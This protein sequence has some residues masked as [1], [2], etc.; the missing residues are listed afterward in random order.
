MAFTN[1]RAQKQAV[2]LILFLPPSQP[3]AAVEAAL[4][5]V[6]HQQRADRAVADQAMEPPHQ[7][8]LAHLGRDTRAATAQP[9]LELAAVVALAR[10]AATTPLAARLEAAAMVFR[11]QSPA[12]PPITAAAVA[13]V[14]GE[15]LAILP[16]DLVGL[17]AA[18][19]ARMVPVRP[20]TA[21][22][23][24]QIPEAAAG[25]LVEAQ[26]PT[27]RTVVMADQVS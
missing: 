25:A 22:T 10:R 27:R 8:R 19:R 14:V 15:A 24:L 3:M 18:E 2:A 17:A 20:Q 26:A 4:E 7:G 13:A 12:R 5:A 16:A 21:L 11:I 9:A 23:E 6:T 1:I